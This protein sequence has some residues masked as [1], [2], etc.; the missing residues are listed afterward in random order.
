VARGIPLRRRYQGFTCFTSRYHQKSLG[1]R[2]SLVGS[3]FHSAEVVGVD[4]LG[5][6][7]A[8]G[9]QWRADTF[10]KRDTFGPQRPVD[11]VGV[12]DVVKG[13][14]LGIAESRR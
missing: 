9:H 8:E 11:H 13:E 4:D 1:V 2:S 6:E 3:G 10:M 5:E 14:D 7:Q 12:E